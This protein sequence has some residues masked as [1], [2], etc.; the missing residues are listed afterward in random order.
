MKRIKSKKSARHRTYEVEIEYSAIQVMEVI[1]NSKREASKL[2]L[3]DLLSEG[4]EIL[5]HHDP[6]VTDKDDLRKDEDDNN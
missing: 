3:D 4:A 1:A 6:I 5:E 2:A